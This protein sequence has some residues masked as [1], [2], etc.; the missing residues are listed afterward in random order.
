MSDN[1]YFTAENPVLRIV[2]ADL[3]CSYGQATRKEGRYGVSAG[4]LS[5]IKRDLFPVAAQPFASDA[6]DQQRTV[7][8]FPET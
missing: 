6:L 1:Y 5:E 8:C 2:F 3:C 7:I 4:L